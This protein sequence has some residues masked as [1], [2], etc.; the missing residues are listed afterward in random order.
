MTTSD[1]TPDWHVDPLQLSQ[2]KEQ[3]R[4]AKN[5]RGLVARKLSLYHTHTTNIRRTA[6]RDSS[7]KAF[8]YKLR[9]E[10]QL[11]ETH[12]IFTTNN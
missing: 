8:A 1:D 2:L 7:N 9:V 12:F 11:N 5:K 4:R 6:H 3:Y 10:N